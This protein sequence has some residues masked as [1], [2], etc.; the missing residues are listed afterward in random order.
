V[1]AIVIG[2]LVDRGLL[3]YDAPVTKYWPEFN[4]LGNKRPIT[5]AD[6]MRHQGGMANM[7]VQIS[8][9]ELM[10]K[11]IHAAL[12]DMVRKIASFEPCFPIQSL[13]SICC[14]CCIRLQARLIESEP[15]HYG[16]TTSRRY[17]A[18]TLGFLQNEIVRRVDPKGRSIGRFIAEEIA[19]PLGIDIYL[20]VPANM[21]HR[22]TNVKQAPLYWSIVHLIIPFVLGGST[23][24]T[25]LSHSTKTLIGMVRQSDSPLSLSGS[26]VA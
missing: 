3:D 15:H 2:M 7:D 21:T 22:I 6:V 11:P 9:K 24:W 16:N 25:E 12:N 23:P 5:I 14:C 17:H 19:S 4:K 18:L 13:N 26:V 1:S 8:L 10:S 20:P